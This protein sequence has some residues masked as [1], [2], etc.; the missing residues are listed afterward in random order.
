MCGIAG[1]LDPTPRPVP[2]GSERWQRPWP[3]PW[4]I[5]GPTTVASGSTP[6]R[7]LHSVTDV[8]PSSIWGRAEHSQ[9]SRPVAA[10]SSPT[11]GR[12]TTTSRSGIDWKR[13]GTTFRGGSDTEVLVAAVERWGID[14][15]LDA[16]EGMFAVAL[17]DRRDTRAP[18]AARPLR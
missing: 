17:W 4:S 5:V 15:A 14:R 11:T 8:W 3:R 16:C 2:T 6:M 13:A 1:L 9:W 12:S 7:G 10:G 18:S